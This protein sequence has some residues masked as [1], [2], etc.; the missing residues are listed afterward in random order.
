MRIELPPQLYGGDPQ[1]FL[2]AAGLRLRS[3]D[4][5][6]R[7]VS[8]EE[9]YVHRQPDLV[10]SA[11]LAGPGAGSDGFGALVRIMSQSV[12]VPRVANATI[13]V[14]QAKIS[15]KA[16]YQPALV[17]VIHSW[18]IDLLVAGD[19]DLPSLAEA[20]AQQIGMAPMDD[21]S[22]PAFPFHGA[23]AVVRSQN[24]GL[25][26]K[27]PAILLHVAQQ[28]KVFQQHHDLIA[29]ESI[30][31]G[32]ANLLEGYALFNLYTA[33]LMGA[34]TPHL[35]GFEATRAF[36]LLVLNFG[37]RPILGLT[38]YP[39]EPMQ[40]LRAGSTP[41]DKSRSNPALDPSSA[42]QAVGF[43]ASKL[44]LMFAQLSDP[45]NFA[46]R[47]GIYDPHA[48]QQWMLS[49]EQLFRRVASIQTSFRD[50]TAGRVLLFTVLDSLPMMSGR[51]LVDMC[52][53]SHAESVL[54][55]IKQ[56]T[57]VDVGRLLFPAAER[58]VEALRAV[59]D[60]FFI[61]R[62][63]SADNVTLTMPDG[64]TQDR[65]PSIAVAQLLKAL[66][67]ATHGFS[68]GKDGNRAQA[69]ALLAQHDAGVPKDLDLLAYLYLI[70]FLFN[71]DRLGRKAAASTRKGR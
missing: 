40:L 60:G 35:W 27:L 37:Q 42:N 13:E 23:T 53:L 10:T 61:R 57:P 34:L 59:Q 48:H 25:R 41:M 43:W 70:E 45:T 65:T 6:Y 26:A 30:F 20:V 66:R 62:R 67:N 47:N 11:I 19:Q 4:G 3:R 5:Q 36:G 9:A 24:L 28:P 71:P 63:N 22:G 12:Q 15:A 51:N 64:T 7:V 49:V 32:S 16:E 2:R 58:A 1:E 44:N 55:K 18:Q 69:D 39:A 31:S 50:S 54:E 52:T 29:T 14:E 21:D 68:G 38:N 17:N 46:D 56:Q 33:P 8:T